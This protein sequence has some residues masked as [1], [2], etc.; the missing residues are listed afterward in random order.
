MT[1]E[2]YSVAIVHGPALS[3]AA[4]LDLEHVCR[5]VESI[6]N[7]V[8]E[9]PKSTLCIQSFVPP[10]RDPADSPN[11]YT[12]LWLEEQGQV[13]LMFAVEFGGKEHKRYSFD[14]HLSQQQMQ[15]DAD[16]MTPTQYASTAS[17]DEYWMFVVAVAARLRV[18]SI[19]IAY[20][21]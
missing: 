6:F 1:H 20:G 8:G 14:D 13:P 4:D 12:Q 3:P 2:S 11:G 10:Y 19:K 5:L 9:R 16:M 21:A 15:L 18:R 7:A 17:H